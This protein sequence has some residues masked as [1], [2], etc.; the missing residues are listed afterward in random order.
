MI[1]AVDLRKFNCYILRNMYNV[2][3]IFSPSH[4]LY[5]LYIDSIIVGNKFSLKITGLN[6]IYK[7]R[8]FVCARVN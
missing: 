4:G 2:E 1:S 7:Q 3:S 5:I 8:K 6:L